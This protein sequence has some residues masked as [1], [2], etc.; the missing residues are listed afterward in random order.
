MRAVLASYPGSYQFLN[1]AHLKTREPDKIHYV[2][3]IEGG[4]ILV[5]HTHTHSFLELYCEKCDGK[6]TGSSKLE[7]S[8]TD[9]FAQGYTYCSKVYRRTFTQ[10]TRSISYFF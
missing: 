10:H 3:D 4:R 1:N 9:M 2:D 8:D 7:S 5:W 6:T